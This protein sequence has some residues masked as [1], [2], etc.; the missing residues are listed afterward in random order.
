MPNVR[1]TQFTKNFAFTQFCELRTNHEK[2]SKNLNHAKST[3][4]VHLVGIYLFG[5]REPL[6]VRDVP[7]PKRMKVIQNEFIIFLTKEHSWFHT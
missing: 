5:G 3:P 6:L 1:Y 4:M 2:Y 7:F